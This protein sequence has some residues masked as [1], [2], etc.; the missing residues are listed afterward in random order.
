MCLCV[1]SSVLCCPLRFP[2]RNDVRDRLYQL[3]AGGLMSYLRYLCLFAHSDG[4]HLSCCV[5]PLFSFVVLPVSLDC[6]LPLRYSLTFICND[7]LLFWSLVVKELTQH[8]RIR[9]DTGI[10]VLSGYTQQYYKP[11]GKTNNEIKAWTT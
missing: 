4:Q 8:T 1:L 7:I 3:F 6:P 5:F 10:K 11:K 2:Y 9:R